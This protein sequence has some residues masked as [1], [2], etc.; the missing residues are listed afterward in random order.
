MRSK[1]VIHLTSINNISR[2]SESC[3]CFLV[4][5]PLITRYFPF[6]LYGFQ[7]F[8]QL[9]CISLVSLIFRYSAQIILENALLCRQNARLKNG[10]FC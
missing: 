6:V 3:E 5:F 2:S 9:L 8:L 4:N 1:I 7:L 10:L